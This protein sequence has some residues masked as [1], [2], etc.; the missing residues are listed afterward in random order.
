MGK[1]CFL[2]GEMGI[3]EAGGEVQ[4][5]GREAALVG[6]GESH[7]LQQRSTDS[8]ERTSLCCSLSAKTE[9]Q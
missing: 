1:Y 7:I 4:C 5:W 2:K 6:T 8:L 9:E 3:G